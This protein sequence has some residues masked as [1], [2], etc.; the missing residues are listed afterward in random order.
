MK[1]PR[2]LLL[3][4]LRKPYVLD[5]VALA[6]RCLKGRA[7]VSRRDLSERVENE[8]VKAVLGLVF[9]GDG[10]ILAAARRVSRAG[11]PL[12]G[13][14]V[15]KLGFLAEINPEELEATLDGLLK[16]M[17]APVER[18]MLQAQVRRRGRLLRQCVAVNDI[19]ISREAFSRIIEMTLYINGQMVNTFRADGLICSTP[20][21]STAH[22]LAAGGPI[23]EPNT[24]AIVI[25]PIC[26]HMM[27]SRPI[28]VDAASRIEVEVRSRSVAFA[29]TADGQVMVKLKNDDRVCVRRNSWPLRLLKVSGRSF[30]ETLRTKLLWEGSP[31]AATNV[32]QKG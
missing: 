28:V 4:N 12:L 2:V 22:S 3:A 21:G 15:G 1:K 19:V 9:G 25:S 8:R 26:P 29:M 6:E 23:I 5:A 7:R 10:A 24:E 13:V 27:S 20:I 18:M 14:N 17:P 11:V 32:T 30:F 31:R 16:E